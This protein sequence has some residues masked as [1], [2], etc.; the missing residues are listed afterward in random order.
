[1]CCGPLFALFGPFL[2]FFCVFLM[3]SDGSIGELEMLKT[4]VLGVLM[5]LQKNEKKRFPAIG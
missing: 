2:T 1:M 3:E 5:P 4:G